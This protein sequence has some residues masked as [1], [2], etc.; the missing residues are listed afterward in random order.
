MCELEER[1][2]AC[3]A[4]SGLSDIHLHI[5]IA[6]RLRVNGKMV[7]CHEKALSRDSL[8][9]FADQHLNQ[10]LMQRWEKYRSIDSDLQCAGQRFRANFYY[11][12]GNP[13]CVLRKIDNVIPS[14]EQLGLPESVQHALQNDRG[15]VLV[16][17]ST[18]A[19]KSTSMAAMA[20]YLLKSR[21]I[22]LITIEDPI[23]F[24]FS[25]EHSLV[26]QRQV[27]T[28]TGSFTAAICAALRQDPDVILLGEM[29]DAE[30]IGLAL[31]AA[32]LGH[33]IIAT[34]HAGNCSDAVARVVHAF[35]AGAGTEF[36]RNQLAESLQ[37]V[38]SQK[39][40][41]SVDGSARIAT[42]EVLLATQA[43]RHLIRNDQIFHLPGIIETSRSDGM[44][45]MSAFSEQ[46][47][48]AGKIRQY[49]A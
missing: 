28:D 39:L 5:G 43:V 40:L 8:R 44:I 4:H 2:A 19:G 49:A 35:G 33:L 10:E 37:L 41:E 42:Y 29:R 21:P 20:A 22:H 15:L 27:G 26:S 32:E 31:T 17:G 7:H 14:M 9:A 11:E 46:L 30:T 38:V 1:I 13:A 16:T 34:L 3:L 12:S 48:A 23:E 18:G 6:P 47:Y 45:T 36:A 24:R 25:S